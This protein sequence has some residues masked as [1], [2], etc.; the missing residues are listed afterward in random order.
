MDSAK[1]EDNIKKIFESVRGE[2]QSNRQKS[3]TKTISFGKH[4]LD[5]TASVTCLCLVGLNDHPDD[6]KSLSQLQTPISQTARYRIASTTN[7]DRQN[8][9]KGTYKTNL[10]WGGGA[11]D[12]PGKKR[13]K[14]PFSSE[15]NNY[16][17]A[18]ERWSLNEDQ[19]TRKSLLD[20]ANKFHNPPAVK[21]QK[22]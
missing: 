17:L 5:S 7:R 4:L 20:L 21:M 22:V 1:I 10:E 8:A 12:H 13:D 18:R 14:R 16:K 11:K 2:G 3:Q 19:F 6:K 9:Y 15:N